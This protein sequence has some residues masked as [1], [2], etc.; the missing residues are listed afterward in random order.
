MTE[1]PPLPDL[2][3]PF[4]QESLAALDDGALDQL[5]GAV[6]TVERA[7]ATA[8]APHQAQLRELR[9]RSGQIATERRRRERAVHIAARAAVR[10]QA[11]SGE[12]PGFSDALGAADFLPE[13]RLLAE[14]PAFLK[15]GGEV[16]FG[17]ATRPGSVAFT[18]GRQAR[19][20]RTWGEARQLFADGWEPGSPGV[21]GVRVHLVGT[22]VERVVDA[23]EVVVRPAG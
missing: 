17:Y 22:R 2:P 1:L 8:M 19:T 11:K 6:A 21:P 7:T 16:R 3:P 20:A 23:A 15:S 10:E 12:M 18:D 13:D 14:V 4:E 5:A 9:A